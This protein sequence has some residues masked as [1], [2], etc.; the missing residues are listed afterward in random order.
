MGASQNEEEKE[1]V[2]RSI[3]KTPRPM[4]MARVKGNAHVMILSRSRHSVSPARDERT[5]PAA[6]AA[7]RIIWLPRASHAAGTV[8]HT[9]AESVG[10]GRHE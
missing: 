8:S 10:D 7:S 6:M 4:P 9:S 1:R 2:G 5:R 3:A